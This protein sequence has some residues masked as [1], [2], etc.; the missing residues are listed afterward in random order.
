MC[1]RE[2]EVDWDKH[3]IRLKTAAAVLDTFDRCVHDL[4][5]ADDQ[6]SAWFSQ[7]V[8]VAQVEFAQSRDGAYRFQRS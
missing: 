3:E 6:P 8:E 2:N 7:P 1:S 4:R 5:E